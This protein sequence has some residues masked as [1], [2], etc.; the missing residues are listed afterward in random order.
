MSENV[1]GPF[2]DSRTRVDECREVSPTQQALQPAHKTFYT[3]TI[4]SDEVN[5]QRQLQGVLQ[6]VYS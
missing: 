1:R 6:V 2:T 5:F 4:F 3:Y